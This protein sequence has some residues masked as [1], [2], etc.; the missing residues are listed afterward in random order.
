[1]AG[2]DPMETKRLLHDDRGSGLDRFPRTGAGSRFGGMENQLLGLVRGTIAEF[3]ATA[4]FVMIGVTAVLNNDLDGGNLVGIALAHG[5]MIF[6]LVSM[7]AHVRYINFKRVL[8][9]RTYFF[10]YTV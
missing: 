9:L 7:T 8:L 3:F 10:V 6:L 5:L 4:M 2:N 1:M